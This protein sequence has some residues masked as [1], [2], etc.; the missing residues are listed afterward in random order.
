MHSASPTGTKLR[1]SWSKENNMTVT[2]DDDDDILDISKIKPKS[3][4]EPL[5]MSGRS[6]YTSTPNDNQ[7]LASQRNGDDDVVYLKRT[8][9][10]EEKK[11]HAKKQGFEYI[12]PYSYLSDN[13]NKRRS[14]QNETPHT[15][16]F[17]SP[18]LSS[19]REIK[20]KLGLH[21]RPT[22]RSTL[23][24]QSFRLDEKAK[25]KRL[26][27]QAAASSSLRDSFSKYNTPAV[28]LFQSTTQSRGKRMVNMVCTKDKTAAIIDLTSNGNDKEKPRLSTK[29]TIKKVLN[30]FDN[31][32]VTVKDSDSDV[33]ILPTPPSPKPDIQ[34]ERVNS[35]KKVIDTKEHT[36]SDWLKKM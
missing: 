32:P 7:R 22:V 14:I 24:D 18:I 26:L 3:W 1:P 36:S 29:E 13:Q 6:H 33:E 20:T 15:R 30:D 9:T 21:K 35:L 4:M 27:S 12:K 11:A 23:L 8:Q 16:D 19:V 10:A 17:T 28:K 25:Y 31:E 2:I 5:K 34:V